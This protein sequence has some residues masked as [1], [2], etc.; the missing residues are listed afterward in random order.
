MSGTTLYMDIS[1]YSRSNDDI[2]TVL[3]I[4]IEKMKLYNGATRENKG[5]ARAGKIMRYLPRG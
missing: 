2:A 3:Y 4:F 1:Q 5:Y